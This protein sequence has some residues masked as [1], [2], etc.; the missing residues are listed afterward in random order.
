MVS[1]ISGYVP[2]FLPMLWP[3]NA[4]FPRFARLKYISNYLRYS[5]ITNINL[6]EIT[7]LLNMYRVHNVILITSLK[8]VLILKHIVC[9]PYQTQSNERT[10]IEYSN[11]C[12]LMSLFQ[13][14][15][16][17][18]T[19]GFFVLHI[20]R[21]WLFIHISFLVMYKLSLREETITTEV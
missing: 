6:F 8:K 2:M 5:W 13:F 16:I 18:C 10:L 17:L 4:S 9:W 21:Y 12:S 3:I 14:Q 19:C 11:V 1:F 15:S 7:R 20:E